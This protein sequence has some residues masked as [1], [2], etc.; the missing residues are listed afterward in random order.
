MKHTRER[1]KYTPFKPRCT[2]I[3]SA[4]SL[5]SVGAARKAAADGFLH[6]WKVSGLARRPS[7]AASAHVVGEGLDHL[8][9][10]AEVEDFRRQTF[11][12]ADVE[13]R[14]AVDPDEYGKQLELEVRDQLQS[15]D[16]VG[17]D[18]RLDAQASG[19]LPCDL[20]DDARGQLHILGLM[21][22]HA[23]QVVRIPGADP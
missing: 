19:R 22:E 4:S 9:V 2:S 21:R 20:D 5:M 7:S 10:R 13:Q 12:G 18:R 23:L 11:V 16:P 3:L 8:P 14:N 6:N 1:S 17:A 15:P